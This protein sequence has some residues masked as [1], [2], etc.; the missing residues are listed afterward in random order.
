MIGKAF[1]Q[2]VQLHFLLVAERLLAFSLLGIF[3]KQPFD[4]GE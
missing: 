3:Q 2:V 4:N 1:L